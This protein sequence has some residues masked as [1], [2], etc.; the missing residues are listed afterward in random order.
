MKKLFFQLLILCGLVLAVTK[1]VDALYRQWFHLDPESSPLFLTSPEIEQPYQ[2]VTVG[3]S[4]AQSGIDFRKY[5]LRGLNLSGVAQRFNF[6]FALLKQRHQQIEDGALI[7]IPVTPISFSHRPAD[8]HDGLQANYYGTL[9]PWLIPDLKIDDYVQMKLL[10][11]VRSGYQIRQYYADAV[12]ERV[13]KE[14][15]WDEP[16]AAPQRAAGAP[17]GDPTELYYALETIQSELASPTAAPVQDYIDNMSFIFHK[18]YETD[19]F[20]TQHF[21]RNR[22]D[23]ERL[24]RYS[25]DHNWRPVLITI[26][27]TEVLQEGLLDDYMQKYL[28]DNLA[29]TDL[30]GVEYIDFSHHSIAQN[31]SLFSNADH[32][33]ERGAAVFSYILLQ[34]LIDR[35]YLPPEADGYY[36]GATF[37]K[38]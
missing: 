8:R 7:L 24:I 21:A 30:Q 23:L 1:G 12:R 9:A 36:Q 6:D 35:G 28:Y 14:E 19:E 34:E 37:T 18:W 20:G 5:N 11:S 31:T 25:L 32:F 4:H 22:K 15:R 10:P 3:N 27:L 29:K 17:I 16:E 33:N 2:I 13:A 26:P 38:E